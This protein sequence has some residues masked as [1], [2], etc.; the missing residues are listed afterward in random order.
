M[1]AAGDKRAL[2]F[3]V[4]RTLEIPNDA[5]IKDFKKGY[6]VVKFTGIKSD[7]SP[8]TD[9]K[10]VDTDFFFFRVAE[11]YLAYAEATARLNGGT[12]T[13]QGIAYLNELR[14]RSGA[15]DLRGFSLREILNERSREFYFEGQRRTDLI[16]YGYFGGDNN[17]MW[18]WKGGAPNGRTFDVRRNIFP[19]PVSDLSVNPNLKQNPGY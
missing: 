15:A 19:L 5:A 10:Y 11:A 1:N 17:Y 16:R 14:K 2:F 9:S 4:D 7:G 18:S 13:T 12:A 8:A 6:S 3:A